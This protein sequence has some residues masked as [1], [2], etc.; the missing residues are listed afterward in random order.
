MEEVTIVITACNRP[1]LLEITINSF[2]QYN[3]YPIKQ[4]IISEDSGNPKVNESLQKKYPDFMWITGRRGQ[5]KSIDEAYS[6]VDTEYVFHLED[7]WETY[8]DGAI[9]E[10]VKILK[11]FPK[12]SA[13]MC[14]DHTPRV[15]HMSENPPL[16]KCWGGWGFYSFNPGL[17]RMSDYK[18]LF[19]TF[20]SFT[21]S[22]EGLSDERK[23]ND[24]FNEK[25]YCMALT[26]D[27]EGYIKHIGDGRHVTIT[28][29]PTL[30]IKI[31]LCMI[32]KNEAHIIHESLGCT[33]P[34]IDTYCIVDTGSTDNTI[35]KIKQF[36]SDKGIEGEVHQSVWKDFGT[37]RSEAL[38]LC[39]GKMDYI[40]V[41]DADDLMKFPANAREI[42]NNLINSANPNGFQMIIRQGDLRYYRAQI[43]KAND[44]WRYMGVLHE[45]PTNLK[46]SVIHKLPDE[47]W[48]ES[49]RLGGRNVAGNKAQRD[50][51]ILTKGLEQEPDNERYMFYLAQ[52]HRD[53]NNNEMAIKYYKQRFKAGRWHEEAWFAAYQVGECYKRLGNI[54]KF[55]YWMQKAFEFRP[56][57][58]EPLYK[59][60]EHYRATANFYKA[61]EYYL[62]GSRVPYPKDDVLFVESNIYNGL[63]QYE[64]SIIEYYIKRENCLRSTIN[65]MLKSPIHQQN[66]IS[67]LKFAV[68]KI[69]ATSI[70]SQDLLGCDTI[71]LDYKNPLISIFENVLKPI[72]FN[73]QYLTIAKISDTSNTY[74]FFIKISERPVE[75]SL[76]FYFNKPGNETCFNLLNVNN[77]IQC[78]VKIDN[79]DTIVSINKENIEW[80]KLVEKS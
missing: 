54:L 14:R 37:N 77:T 5:I 73:N 33:L 10:S 23:L 19:G 59:L 67:N 22:G 32:V 42:L 4:W 51:D 27:P 16:L 47:F 52:S 9:V 60:L 15:Y 35:E 79:V 56:C 26:P 38:K 65:F 45:Y 39:D 80:V 46:Q 69:E 40:L 58:A 72:N 21:N 12:V 31:G 25:G 74:H 53:N 70:V 49:R 36:Y 1:D 30:P 2:L 44:D 48:M 17:R 20:S 75:I 13:V 78:F 64:A 62:K 24:F 66:C 55:E 61:Y 34:L 71:T 50:V 76:P 7:D 68:K 63:F 18:T 43:F 3:T 8:K 57:R 29:D 41:I 11:E 28:R 6:H